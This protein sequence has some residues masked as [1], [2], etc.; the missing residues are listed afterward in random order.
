MANPFEV[1][2]NT[3]PTGIS[4][5]RL[6]VTDGVA[7]FNYHKHQVGGGSIGALGVNTIHGYVGNAVASDIACGT[8][9]GGGLNNYENIVGG[10]GSVTVNTATPNVASTGTN[11]N[12]SCI[13]G[14]YDNVA[15]G[16]ASVIN[17]FH[18]VTYVGT[19]HGTVCGGSVQKIEAGDY[20]TIGAGQLHRIRGGTS[21][22]TIMGG[23]A[24]DINAASGQN[25]A[26]I[27]G[28]FTNTCSAAFAAIGG[29]SNN[30][31]SGSG[32]AIPGGR[33]NTAS[34]EAAAAIGYG[35]VATNPGALARAG[36]Y[37]SAA[38]D[39]QAIQIVLRRQT[40]DATPTELRPSST[41][42]TRLILVN[43]STYAF[44]GLIAARNTGSD[45][46]S[47]AYKIEGCID[48]TAGGT[49]A[50]VGTPTVAVIAEDVAGWDVSVAA[51]N[52][53]KALQI[54]VTGEAAKTINW[55][56]DIHL[57]KVTG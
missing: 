13:G 32:A 52:T 54:L 20:N 10:D 56:G 28:G 46:E 3:P 43:D 4:A 21:Y 42:G 36:G 41:L 48:V 1:G 44:K 11:A 45:T 50:L 2:I 17:G 18:N 23:G 22:G 6:G 53:N 12:Y 24:N 27:G 26:T 49:T 40:T 34:A 9:G 30:T 39:A 7:L 14:G 19:T 35:A 51:D 5:S 37:F 16:L 15:G 8:I 33:Y 57:V 29:G 31:A 55:V 25:Y 47:A 38:G